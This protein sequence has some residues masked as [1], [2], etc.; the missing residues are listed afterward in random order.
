MTNLLLILL[1]LVGCSEDAATESEE[2]TFDIIGSWQ[3]D[4]PHSNIWD[5]TTGIIIF[6]EDSTLS[7]MI[8]GEDNYEILGTYT[9]D[10]EINRITI[11]DNE[12]P[13]PTL[14]GIYD[15]NI[16]ETELTLT[17]VSDECGEDRAIFIANE[18]T[19]VWERI[20]ND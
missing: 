7:F 20:I 19:A 14:E 15:Y 8:V 16:S 10:S 17:L 9:P 11:I 1:L 12:C 13:P 2:N 3:R 4:I 6:N 18:S 5:A